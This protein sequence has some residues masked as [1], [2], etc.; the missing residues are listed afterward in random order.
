MRN[1]KRAKRLKRKSK[2][3]FFSGSCGFSSYIVG[4]IA[5]ELIFLVSTFRCSCK[6]ICCLMWDLKLFL[7]NHF[8]RLCFFV[9][10]VPCG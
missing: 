3:C 7:L 4:L 6:R 5:T 1:W 9:I 10:F 2:N 8:F